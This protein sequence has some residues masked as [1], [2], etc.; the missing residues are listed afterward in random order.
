MSSQWNN[1][2]RGAGGGGGA[3]GR[4]SWKQGAAGRGGGGNSN[5]GGGGG[6]TTNPKKPKPQEEDEMMDTEDL[7]LAFMEDSEMMDDDMTGLIGEEDQTVTTITYA[8]W[9]R[10]KIGKGDFSPK[11]DK[12][13]FQQIDLDHYIHSTPVQGMPGARIGPVPVIRYLFLFNL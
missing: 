5:T 1:R 3:G 13:T 8:Q 6:D 10:P 9:E 2:K 12:L 4:G 7:E 11:K